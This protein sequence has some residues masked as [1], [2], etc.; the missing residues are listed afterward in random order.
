MAGTPG[1]QYRHADDYAAQ[2]NAF[3]AD[4]DRYVVYSPAT[5]GAYPNAWLPVNLTSA[6]LYTHPGYGALARG[7]RLAAQ[8]VPYDYGGNV[9]IQNDAVYVNGDAAG[10][11]EEY[12][13]QATQIAGA[14]QAA[15]PPA[16]SKWLPLGVFAVAEGDATSSDDVFQLAINP[17]GIIRGNYHNLKTDECVP[18][19]GSVDQKSQ[20][21]AWTIGGDQAPVYETGIANL[22]KDTASLLVHLADGTSNQ[23][24]LIRLQQPAGDSAA[25]STPPTQ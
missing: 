7:C 13:S 22:T 5:F 1:T 20:R 2:A 4:A 15:E 18:I 12:A 6:S 19:S 3:H 17:Q 21:A 23:L 10:T 8:P 16:D 25:G 11:P 14:G 9:V 24:T